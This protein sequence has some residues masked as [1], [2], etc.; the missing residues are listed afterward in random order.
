MLLQTDVLQI[1]S[2]EAG[3]LCNCIHVNGDSSLTGLNND[4]KTELI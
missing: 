1:H 2:K 3:Y 4:N